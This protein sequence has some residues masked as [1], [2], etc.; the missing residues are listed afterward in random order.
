V[1]NNLPSCVFQRML[2][3]ESSVYSPSTAVLRRI[4]E[5]IT[6][7][8]S[9]VTLH[10]ADLPINQC[11]TVENRWARMRSIVYFRRQVSFDQFN[12][13]AADVSF[14]SRRVADVSRT[15]S[16]SCI[17]TTDTPFGCDPPRRSCLCRQTVDPTKKLFV[18]FVKQRRTSI[19]PS[20]DR[21]L[22]FASSR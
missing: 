9:I 21:H 6:C 17:R 19:D 5:Q 4:D 13:R 20:I 3:D 16:V 7:A 10:I 22:L 18:L 11:F 15:T 8:H 2:N 1:S 12:A 14:V